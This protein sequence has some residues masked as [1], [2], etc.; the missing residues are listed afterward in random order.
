MKYSHGGSLNRIFSAVVALAL[1]AF[2]SVPSLAAG[3]CSGY[4]ASSTCVTAANVTDTGS[5]LTLYG[6]LVQT[7]TQLGAE[8]GVF[9]VYG[10]TTIFVTSQFLNITSSAAVG[11]A[12]V[13]TTTPTIAT[14]TVAGANLPFGQTLVITSTVAS[15]GAVFQANG[16][17]SGTLLYLGAA[18]RTV[19]N[20]NT[21]SL[22]LTPDSA[23]GQGVWHETSFV[24][25]Q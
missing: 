11:G 12:V 8:G 25:G 22:I 14:T 7:P 24:T 6:P 9:G 3:S 10:T 23:T 15:Y 18:S 16:T 2:H 1:L 21:L 19:N 4:L 5:G 13:M 20:K 17:L